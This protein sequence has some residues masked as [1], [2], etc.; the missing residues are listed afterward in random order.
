MTRT[1]RDALAEELEA[2]R[3]HGITV[4][5]KLDD[6]VYLVVAR[7]CTLNDLDDNDRPEMPIW[8]LRTVVVDFADSNLSETDN[9]MWIPREEGDIT[10]SLTSLLAV[11]TT[12]LGSSDSELDPRLD[13]AVEDLEPELVLDRE[14]EESEEQQ[15][16]WTQHTDKM[17]DHG[18]I[19]P[20]RQWGYG[21]GPPPEISL[22]EE[23]L[24]EI[25]EEPSDHTHRLVWGKKEPMDREPRPIEELTGNY[26]VELLP[27]SSGLIALDVDYPE[28]VPADI[29]LP[30]TLEVSS[31]HGGK[32]QRHIIVR[33]ESKSEIA[34]EL[35]GWAVQS[36]EWGDL[37]IGDRYLVGPGSQL[38]E[39]G[40][41]EGD[42]TRGDRGGCPE[43]SDPDGGYYE[44][45]N[46]SEIAEVSPDWIL[47]I[48]Q[49]SRG[50]ETELRDEETAPDPPEKNSD[51]DPN[52]DPDKL[53]C[54]SCG[55]LLE[56]S[57]AHQI[58]LGATSKVICDGGCK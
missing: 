11:S 42:H 39:W 13:S 20:A 5:R 3:I 4:S 17:Q 28:H 55:A 19:D 51:Q 41:G 47:S 57:E 2:E 25:G 52:P 46:D 18:G 24:E 29:C 16:E 54:D 8:D 26:G 7:D 32:Q 36:L 50:S 43:C 27:K 33:C 37:W 49:R 30:D 44:I 38:S 35:G 9:G 22:L 53:E 15:S 31:P 1:V 12:N 14:L 10:E 56:E 45:I 34:N 23:R 58:E 40:C 21:A 6:R 48:V